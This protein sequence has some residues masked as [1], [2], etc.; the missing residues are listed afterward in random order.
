MASPDADL[1]R[2]VMLSEGEAPAEMR[3]SLPKRPVVGRDLD[4]SLSLKVS[5]PLTGGKIRFGARSG[6][7][8][9]AD[10]S[11]YEF[12]ATQP[13]QSLPFTV[14]VRPGSEGVG[15]LVAMLEGVT[16]DGPFQAEYVVPVIA[17][18]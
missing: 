14:S 12:G 13:G 1:V 3:F 16:L 15:E 6:L 9:T 18:P 11:A 5:R 17:T 2:A 4:V 8:L 7:A 10:V